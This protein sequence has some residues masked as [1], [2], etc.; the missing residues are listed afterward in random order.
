MNKMSNLTWKKYL[1]NRLIAKPHPEYS[2][3]VPDD[4]DDTKS[5]GLSC[6]V[7]DHLYRNRDDEVAALEFDCCHMCALQWAHSRKNDWL[8]GWRPSRDQ[9]TES[10]A[11]RP[12]MQVK[13]E[14]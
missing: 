14:I 2:I 5:I 11:N 6:P 4:Y 12:P 1:N 3:I 10:L 8:N 13:L 9:V 7:C